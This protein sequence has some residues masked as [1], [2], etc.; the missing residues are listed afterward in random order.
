MFENSFTIKRPFGVSVFGSGLIRVAPDIALIRA[1]VSVL[2]EKPSEVFKEARSGV[3]RVTSFLARFNGLEFGASRVRLNGERR[4]IG[5][6]HRFV[7]YRAVVGIHVQLRDLDHLEKIALGMVEA[8][9]NEIT[10]IDF[11]TSELKK[12]RSEA[13]TMAI[14]AAYEKGL[15]YASSA[16]V[17]LGKVIHIQDLNPQVLQA[18]HRQARGHEPGPGNPDSD[19]E[20]GGQ[21]LDPAAI[22]V[23]AAVLIAYAIQ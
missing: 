5:G 23:N 19:A 21:F 3:E 11:Q 9:A 20:S 15:L 4:F 18:M 1:A 16:G 14:K 22:E 12:L 13:R 17:Q 6:E 7:G 10:S 8:G 2:N